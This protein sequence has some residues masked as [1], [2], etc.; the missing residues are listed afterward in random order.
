[1]VFQLGDDEWA[2]KYEENLHKQGVCTEH[3]GHVD[4]QKTGMAQINVA[5]NGENQIV[6]IPGANNSLSSADVEAA[7]DIL[8]LSK[9]WKMS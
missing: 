4:G 7:D 2:S 8:K 1:M 9:V 6:I 3:V 5:E